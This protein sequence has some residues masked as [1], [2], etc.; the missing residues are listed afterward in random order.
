MISFMSNAAQEKVYLKYYKGTHSK[1]TTVLRS[2]Q[3]PSIDVIY[4]NEALQILVSE[5][6]DP[7]TGGGGYADN[8]ET[9]VVTKGPLLTS[10]VGWGQSPD[11][12][13]Y[14]PIVR[15][16]FS[17]KK[18]RAYTGCYPL[19]LAKVL[20]HNRKPE[21]YTYHDHTFNWVLME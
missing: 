3:Q 12:N 8:K 15:K 2:P 16:P 14:C 9:D 4:D 10:F 1:N 7:G 19:A 5:W 21:T 18:R 13:I 11:L 20:A 17:H 6:E